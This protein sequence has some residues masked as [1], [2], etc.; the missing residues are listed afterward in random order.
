MP[1]GVPLSYYLVQLHVPSRPN[2]ALANQLHIRPHP[3][4]AWSQVALYIDST[5][6]PCRRYNRLLTLVAYAS[7]WA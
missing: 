7:L 4:P 5:P 2:S 1:P 6:F 3:P